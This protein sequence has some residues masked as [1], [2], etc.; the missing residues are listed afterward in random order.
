MG[1]GTTT[2]VCLIIPLNNVPFG[3][4]TVVRPIQIFQNKVPAIGGNT[5]QKE[6][7]ETCRKERLDD[8]LRRSK[9]R[10]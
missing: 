8:I 3:I 10:K 9:Y 1:N 4:V 6:M 5:I 2:G 7:F